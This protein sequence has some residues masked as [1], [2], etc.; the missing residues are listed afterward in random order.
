[1][2]AV[3]GRLQPREVIELS[4]SSVAESWVD[5]QAAAFEAR[6]DLGRAYA[7]VKRRRDPLTSLFAADQRLLRLSDFAHRRA[8]EAEGLSF[9]AKGQISLFDGCLDGEDGPSRR[10]A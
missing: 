5:V 8:G 10:G 9:I 7:D 6:R 3:L 1:M 4:R 2:P